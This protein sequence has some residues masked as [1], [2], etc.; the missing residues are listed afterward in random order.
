[1]IS[2]GESTVPDKVTPLALAD[3]AW[4]KR[5]NDDNK[6]APDGWFTE[7]ATREFAAAHG[8]DWR[9]VEAWG[10]W[11]RWNGRYWQRERTQ[12]VRHHIRLTIARMLRRKSRRVSGSLVGFVERYAQS[13]REIARDETIWDQDP[14]LLN[15][16]T[17]TLDLRTA[18]L[19]PYRRDDHLTKMAAAAPRG[20]CP[21][22][23]QFIEE[24][25]NND[26]ELAAYLQRV[27]GYCL[28]GLTREEAFFFAY[29]PGGNGKGTFLETI[30]AVMGDYACA[31]ASEIF[32]T[33]KFERHPTEIAD[34]R[35]HRLVTADEI[36][37]GARWNES[38]LK[39][40]TGGG[41]VSARYMRQDLFTFRP[42]FK[43]F[44]AGNNRPGLSS[45]DEAIRRRLH[46]LPFTQTFRDEGRDLHLKSAL[47]EERDGILQ[48][49]V[50]GCLSWQAEGLNP[51]Q[52]VHEATES[53]LDEQDTVARW[54]A[55]RCDL[56]NSYHATSAELFADWKQWGEIN[57][58]LVG[59]KRAFA[60]ALESHG[61]KRKK[62]GGARSYVGVRLRATTSG[63]VPP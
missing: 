30:S 10:Y 34:L 54:L 11:L 45:V 5:A 29:G 46:L 7:Q 60:D 27:A 15:T 40:L 32:M 6:P 17:G 37:N 8:E 43:L 20:E 25:T 50:E 18:E 19:H 14:W 13:T 28:T 47:L 59:T 31:V 33:S 23:K 2:L 4:S 61:C 1:M 38:R 35:G 53:Y 49:M 42:A 22:W 57:G 44:I 36:R 52:A 3:A 24:I 16:A 9:Y 56:D 39:G 21:R 26:A 12:L 41:M 63:E 55:E 58:E 51:P 48:W 62:V